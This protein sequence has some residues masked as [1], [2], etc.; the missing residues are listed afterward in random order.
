[1]HANYAADIVAWADAQAQALRTRSANMLDWDNLAAEVE[2]LVASEKREVRTRLA[3]IMHHMLKWQYQPELR[4]RSWRLT[5][6]VQR[7]DLSALM[8]DSPSLRSFALEVLDT[9]YRHG[10]D[11]AE[12]E[13]GLLSLPMACPWS[14][15]QVLDQRFLPEA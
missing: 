13:T 7:R 6:Q 1:M 5:L 9:S 14:L 8:E 4:S 12:L 10:R 11:D 15:D 3:L 2:G